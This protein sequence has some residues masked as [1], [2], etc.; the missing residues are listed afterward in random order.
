DSGM[1]LARL[2]GIVKSFPGVKAVKGVD[3]EVRPG[4]V[5]ALV[6]ENG[7]GKS[8][9]MRMLAG[10]ERP[11][12]GTIIWRGQDQSFHDPADAFRAGIAMIYQELSLLPG[13]SVAENIFLAHERLRRG[14]LINWRAMGSDAGGLL[15]SLGVANDQG[16]NVPVDALPVAARQ[17]V[18]VA[19]ALS[20][21]ASLII[22][23][24]P[25]ASL[26]EGEVRTLFEVIRNLR[27]RGVSVVYVSHRLEEVLEIADRVTV[28]R[29][30]ELVRTLSAAEAS[31]DLLIRLMVG[32]DL[33]APKRRDGE[34]GETVL[35]VRGLRVPLRIQ[36]I[37]L[38]VRTGEIVALWGLI[39]SG[40]STLARALAGLLPATATRL[41]VDGS[42][43]PLSDA[44]AAVRAGVV[45]LTE[46]RKDEGLMLD[47]SVR[48]NV[49]LA[50]LS[51]RSM[52]GFV[53]AAD[54]TKRV[55]EIT[56]DLRVRPPS[57]GAPVRNLSGGN[58][59]R[60]V[61]ARAL[62]AK[63][64][65]LIV[66]E[67]TRGIDVGSKAEIHRLLRQLA[68]EGH[69]VLLV[70]SE[71][72]EVLGLADRIV[73][74]REG[75]A[76]GEVEAEGAVEDDLLAMATPRR[77]VEAASERVRGRVSLPSGLPAALILVGLWLAAAAL[78]PEFQSITNQANLLSQAAVLALLTLGQAI[79][80][81]GGGIDLSVG[82][83]L[84]ASLTLSATIMS[85]RDAQMVPAIGAALAVGAAIGFVNGVVVQRLRIQPF[86][87]TLGMAVV[88]QGLVLTW[89]TAPTGLAAPAFFD[90]AASRVFRLPVLGLIAL[91]VGAVAALTLRHHVWGRRVY[92]VGDDADA[93][94]LS[95]IAVDSVRVWS[96]V[97]CGVLAA[98]AGLLTLARFGAADP[99]VGV[100]LEFLSI[101][102]AVVGGVSLAGGRGTL[103]G[104]LAGVGVLGIIANMVNQLGVQR[105]W[106]QVVTGLMILIAV[107]LFQ[108]TG[109]KGAEPLA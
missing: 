11:D 36:T 83:T 96:Y 21:N 42:K 45:Y 80:L 28:L 41:T 68:D 17:M 30:G 24:E 25:T 88:V 105:Y 63:P 35:S 108:R 14:G 94:R 100:G 7:A 2:Q 98:L 22:M 92:A 33:P 61:M 31:V 54:E 66:D 18:E 27:E 29:D 10:S 23:D 5:H 60:V 75:A 67:P 78:S 65:V 38:D 8:T 46:N 13:L 73:V 103:W 9:L 90:L 97:V 107:Y 56:R 44:P 57:L 84:T 76:V 87:A 70:S 79:V 52:A 43:T 71:L 49:S 6:G 32:R 53:R 106:Q 85:G 59:Q 12:V 64:R 20:R 74:M 95:G 39:G 34:T 58:Q 93:A 62:L 26:G 48:E 77:R 19:K 101:T 51:D 15:A 104:A 16:P 82:A 40:R 109:G 102:A 50:S 1:A 72:P 55:A 86:I 81:I 89:V 69:A 37:D 91:G 4:E 99:Q 47:R 3:L